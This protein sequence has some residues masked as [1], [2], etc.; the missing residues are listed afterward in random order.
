MLAVEGDYRLRMNDLSMSWFVPYR[1]ELVTII[2]AHAERFDEIGIPLQS[3]SDRILRAM[4]R[5]HTATEA[6]ESIGALRSAAPHIRLVTHVIIGFPGETETDFAQTIDLVQPL[7]F[8]RVDIYP[9]DDRPGTPASMMPEKVPP[10]TK[11]RRI[12][13]MRKCCHCGLRTW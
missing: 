13:Q 11:S 7:G 3:G 6:G 9:Y 1:D 10:R 8:D 2:G 12:A 4:R 5:G